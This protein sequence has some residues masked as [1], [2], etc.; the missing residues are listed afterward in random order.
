MLNKRRAGGAGP[1]HLFLVAGTGKS[2]PGGKK[3]PE[4]WPIT[5]IAHAGPTPYVYIENY[6]ARCQ[7]ENVANRRTGSLVS[8]DILVLGVIAVVAFL[9]LRSV[10]GKKTGN[11]E[12]RAQSRRMSAPDAAQRE[13]AAQP[14]AEPLEAVGGRASSIDEFAEPGSPLA[15]ALTEIQL[16]DSAFDPGS[17]M[18][19]ARAAY[20]MIISAFAS[21]DKKTLKPLLSDE[22][23][24][25]FSTVVDDRAKVK[26]T[27][28]QTFIGVNTSKISGAA[29]TDR[30]AEITVKFVSELISVTK[31]SDGAVI[32][33]DPNHVF[34]VTDIWTFSRD[35]KSSDPNWRVSATVSG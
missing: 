29:L 21:G 35:T 32:Q 11:E 6:P 18:S 3:R 30:I 24:S 19:G 7:Q 13:R 26:E 27:V 20:E 5:P 4:I 12:T 34:K 1:D 14:A 22:V 25:S 28:D 15:Q 8:F 9:M 10:L 23:F 33:G 31:N 17:F 16:A 2:H